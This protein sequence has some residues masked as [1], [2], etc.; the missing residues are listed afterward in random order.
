MQVD[1]LGDIY[2][3]NG[4]ACWTIPPDTTE[5]AKSDASRGR[6]VDAREGALSTAAPDAVAAGQREAI[7]L[8]RF[9]KT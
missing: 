1:D 8:R 6:S 9:N 2:D 3:R 7:T 4:G 5:W